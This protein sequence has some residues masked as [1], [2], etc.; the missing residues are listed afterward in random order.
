[1]TM[2]GRD[3]TS[4][5]ELLW[6]PAADY[7]DLCTEWSVP[8]CCVR[9]GRTVGP[10]MK[11]LTSLSPLAAVTGA[12]TAGALLETRISRGSGR[13]LRRRDSWRCAR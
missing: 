4:R 1:M 13:E 11:L 8:A 2:P 3:S 6:S 5:R 7:P 9:G 12:P 10:G